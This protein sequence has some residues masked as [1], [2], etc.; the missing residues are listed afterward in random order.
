MVMGTRLLLAGARQSGHRGGN[1][2]VFSHSAAGDKVSREGRAG[3]FSRISESWQTRSLSSMGVHPIDQTERYP[4]TNRVPVHFAETGGFVD[5][6]QYA[7]RRRIAAAISATTC[8]GMTDS[9]N[10]RGH[11]PDPLRGFYVCFLCCV[12]FE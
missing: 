4:V 5:R 11:Y 6:E 9:V 3:R 2:R 7:P 10:P 12:Y 1:R 8:L